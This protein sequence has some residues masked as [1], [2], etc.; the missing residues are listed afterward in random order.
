MPQK[1]GTPKKKP[2]KKRSAVS[3]LGQPREVQRIALEKL[4]FDTK[5]PRLPKSAD[6]NDDTAV[7]EWML[8]NANVTELMG[9]IAEQGYFDGEP[10]IVIPSPKTGY[11]EVVEGNRRLTATKLLNNPNLAPAKKRAVALISENAKYRPSELPCLVF[12]KR[13]DV[14]HFLAYRH[15]TG[16]EPWKPLQKARYLRQLAETPAFKSLGKEELRR[17]LAQEIG[18]NSNYVARLMA[19]LAV[20][21]EIADTNNFFNIKGLNEDD[22]S[23]SV[24][25][26]ALTSFSNIAHYVGMLSSTDDDVSKLKKKE[27]E[28]LTRWLFEENNEG[29]ARVAESRELKVLN[30][31]LANEAARERFVAGQPLAEADLLTEGP[32]EAFRESVK[33][34]RERLKIA[35][36]CA[37]LVTDYTSNDEEILRDLLSM[38]RFLHVNV[39]DRLTENQGKAIK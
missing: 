37:H 29:I 17:R 39:Q 11:F 32:S 4:L 1:T 27:L 5:N 31:V 25:S 30:R 2:Q 8:E 14:L 10:L 15:I 3:P 26:T 7:I 16:I 6:S 9:S 33:S 24:L 35:R 21:D 38:V 13:S 23:F 22:V 36:D 18:S 28:Q 20:Y 12:E 19:A 34:A